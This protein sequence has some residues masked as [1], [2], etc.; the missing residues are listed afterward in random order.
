MDENKKIYLTFDM[1]WA[2]DEIMDFLYDILEQYDVSA[3][4]NVT[5]SFRSLEKYKM[6]KRIN[7]GIHPNFNKLLDGITEGGG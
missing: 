3:T 2:C 1:D 6:S 4:I 5:N 7:L